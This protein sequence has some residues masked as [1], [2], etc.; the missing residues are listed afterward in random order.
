MRRIQVQQQ[1]SETRTL[2]EEPRAIPVSRDAGAAQ[3]L[4]DATLVLA[5]ID[6]VLADQA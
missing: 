6:D 2:S 5:L 1:R 3:M 4:D